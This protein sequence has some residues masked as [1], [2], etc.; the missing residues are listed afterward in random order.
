MEINYLHKKDLES[1]QGLLN[2]FEFNYYKIYSPE[3][4]LADRQLFRS[5]KGLFSKGAKA[6][7]ARDNSSIIGL[8]VLIDLPWET[9]YFGFKMA[10]I[11]YLIVKDGLKDAC[12]IKNYLLS[13]IQDIGRKEKIGHVSS[14]VHAGDFS[15]IRALEEGGFSLMG[16]QLTYLL[17]LKTY[18]MPVFKE[19]CRVRP[20]KKRDLKELME[21]AQKFPPQETR[22]AIDEHLPSQKRKNAY[23]AEWILNSARDKFSD[24]LIVAERNNKIVGFISCSLNKELKQAFGI[25]CLHQGLIIVSPEAKGSSL[26]LLKYVATHRGSNFKA[27]LFEFITYMHNF[28]M[29]RVFQKLGFPLVRAQYCFSKRLNN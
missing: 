22:F 8:A 4:H 14:K 29:I 26:S 11:K 25:N 21:L 28:P 10:E 6:I 19:V 23:Y 9:K 3:E 24:M 27:G 1:L 20:F 17:N 13:F 7:A 18:R 15:G 16:N 2:G 12:G 5:I